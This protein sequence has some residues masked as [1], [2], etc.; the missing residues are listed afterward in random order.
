LGSKV[1]SLL[2]IGTAIAAVIGLLVSTFV[3]PTFG[4]SAVFTLF[5][6]MNLTSML[7]LFLFED[8]K[9]LNDETKP[10]YYERP[11]YVSGSKKAHSFS[12]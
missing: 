1:Y 12:K 9:V 6:M 3:L 4:W 10:S 2:F 11:L 8:N 7:L 5:G